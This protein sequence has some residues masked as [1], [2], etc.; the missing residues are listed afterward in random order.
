MIIR[1]NQ[2]LQNVIKILY[3][4]TF[5]PDY[6]RLGISGLTPDMKSLLFRRVAGDITSVTPKKTKVKLN[7]CLVDV[8]DFQQYVSMYIGNKS[9][10]PRVYEQMGDRWEYCVTANL[11]EEFAHISFVNGIYTNKGG[12]HVEYLM[13]QIVKKLLMYIKK[14]EKVDVKAS[15]IKEQIMIFVN[16]VI[17]N[18]SF[19]S[20]TK[21]YMNTPVAKFGSTCDISDKFVEKVAQLGLMDMAISLD[22]N[23]RYK[24]NKK[25]DG[26][27]TNHTWYTKTNRCEFCR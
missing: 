19:D 8:K 9:V 18:P 1:K 27:K 14:K 3:K 12:R 6:K 17:E 13:N 15:T 26:S 2:K 4:I 11:V 7:N 23:K 5:K 16:S 10:K 25:T 21:D 22:R 24:I 20:Q